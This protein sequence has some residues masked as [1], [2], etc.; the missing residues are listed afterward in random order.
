MVSSSRRLQPRKTSRECKGR[1]MMSVELTRAHPSPPSGVDSQRIPLCV[2]KF[3]NIWYPGIPPIFFVSRF[4]PSRATNASWNWRQTKAGE[5]SVLSQHFL[6]QLD[7]SFPLVNKEEGWSGTNLSF[8]CWRD[9]YHQGRCYHR[10]DLGVRARRE[11]LTDRVERGSIRRGDGGGG[12]GR[13]DVE[14]E[15][16]WSCDEETGETQSTR[17]E[18]MQVEGDDVE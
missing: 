1:K 5:S 15:K 9:V 4:W 16:E 14:E 13:E 11:A 8:G 3:S 10:L 2:Y 7:L 17:Q 18:T 6:S 12:G